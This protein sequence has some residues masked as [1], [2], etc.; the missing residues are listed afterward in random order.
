MKKLFFLLLCLPVLAHGQ[1][2]RVNLVADAAPISITITGSFS[3]FNN[4]TGT[5]S[6]SQFV[7]VAG[8]GLTN[9]INIPVPSGFEGSPDNATWVTT[10]VSYTLTGGQ[11]VG[12]KFYMRVK[13]TTAA[14]SYSGNAVAASSPAASVNIPYSA[15]VS[16]V[17]FLSASPTSISGMTAVQGSTG[18]PVNDTVTF[19]GLTGSVTATASSNFEC[20]VD[21]GLTY[22]PVEGFSTGSPYKVRVR[23]TSGAPLGGVSGNIAYTNAGVSTVTVPLSGTVASS[24]STS[25]TARFAMSATSQTVPTGFISFFGDPSTG[26]RTASNAA[27]NI[28]I[29]TVS[30]ANW[31]I[32]SGQ[33]CANDADG[34]TGST[35]SGFPDNIL[36]AQMFTYSGGGALADSAS[37]GLLK[38]NFKI[39]GLNA[40][41]TYHIE[42]T[43][44]LDGSRFGLT[45]TNQFYALGAGTLATI[46]TNPA[47]GTTLNELSN[48]T[49]KLVLSS[50]TPSGSGVI[51]L[52]I[53][54]VPGQE[55][56]LISGLQ[57]WKN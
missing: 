53:F 29:S 19:A 30:T 21:G 50:V 23:I 37:Q 55:I 52:Y 39:S 35:V 17:P 33:G 43:A 41:A 11:V 18:T 38:P 36:K 44:N 51:N 13:S 3:A 57:I 4:V 24:G 14:G 45:C 5:S 40:S 10:S 15:T 16:P 56:A 1:L 2:L 48:K 34:Q 6:A 47:G 7:G 26:V 12:Q 20:S 8:T 42:M 22:G 31:S 25:D 28:I 9:P 54:T 32:V 49:Q 27:G 46:A